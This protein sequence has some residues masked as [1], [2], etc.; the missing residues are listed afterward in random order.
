MVSP[1]AGGSSRP[2]RLRP[3][4]LRDRAQEHAQQLLAAGRLVARRA[5]LDAAQYWVTV[6]MTKI[7]GS[8][9]R[10]FASQ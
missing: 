4:A 8:Y 9:E 3:G 5:V 6:A 2:P 7:A 1:H 10:L